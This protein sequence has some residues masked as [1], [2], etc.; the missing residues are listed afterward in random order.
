MSIFDICIAQLILIKIEED[1]MK[2]WIAGHLLTVDDFKAEN[3]IPLS[4]QEFYISLSMVCVALALFGIV[5]RV[6]GA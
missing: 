4:N 2:Q 5:V 6:L 3:N 1:Q